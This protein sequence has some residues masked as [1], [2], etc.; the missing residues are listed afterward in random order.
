MFFSKLSVPLVLALCHAIVAENNLL[1]VRLLIPMAL[2]TWNGIKLLAIHHLPAYVSLHVPSLPR[3][4]CLVVVVSHPRHW[5]RII[6][7]FYSRPES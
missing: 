3:L 7:F 5:L 1:R 4:L 2:D 6:C